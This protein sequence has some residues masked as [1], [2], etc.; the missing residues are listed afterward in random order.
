MRRCAGAGGHRASSGAVPAT[1]RFGVGIEVGAG[2]GLVSV[3]GT[4]PEID[5]GS[6]VGTGSG[7]SP[8]VGSGTRVGVGSGSG[9]RLGVGS[10]PRV[11]TGSGSGSGSG[12]GVGVGSGPRV[13][14]GSGSHVG[15]GSGRRVGARVGVGTGICAGLGTDSAEDRLR[16]PW[17]AFRRPAWRG[18]CAAHGPVLASAAPGARIRWRARRATGPRSVVAGGVPRGHLSDGEPVGWAVRRGA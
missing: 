3:P 14:V 1:R 18:M 4:G 16:R 8:E 5:S 7:T 17:P 11:G 10:G 15:V 6:G 9:P 2:V 13:S 12:T